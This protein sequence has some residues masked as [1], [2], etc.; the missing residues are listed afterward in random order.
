VNFL[1]GCEKRLTAAAGALSAAERTNASD[2]ASGY[3]PFLAVV[4]IEQV[5]GTDPIGDLVDPAERARILDAYRDALHKNAIAR[6]LPDDPGRIATAIVIESIDASEKHRGKLAD[7]LVALCSFTEA[8]AAEI[9]RCKVQRLRWLGHSDAHIESLH[10]RAAS[11][12]GAVTETFEQWFYVMWMLAGFL[13]VGSCSYQLFGPAAARCSDQLHG[14][15]SRNLWAYVPGIVNCGPGVLAIAGVLGGYLGAIAGVFISGWFAKRTVPG[16][17]A[18][19]IGRLT[20]IAVA[21]L[22]PGLW[23]VAAWSAQG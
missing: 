12:G 10:R 9:E 21:I 22:P 3:G 5:S 11:V 8:T 17:S 16:T 23:L 6:P 7:E 2:F 20:A 15:F 4:P 13:G 18:R 14:V 1:E 19:L